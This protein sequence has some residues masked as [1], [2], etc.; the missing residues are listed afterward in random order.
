MGTVYATGLVFAFFPAR[1]LGSTFIFATMTHIFGV[2]GVSYG[3]YGSYARLTGFWDNGLRWNVPDY[4]L[5]KFDATSRYEQSSFFK[6]LR[7]RLDE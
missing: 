3:L 4:N 5:V 7:V 2:C 1:G 6:R